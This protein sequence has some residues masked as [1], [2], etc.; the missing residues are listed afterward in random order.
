MHLKQV[1]EG[2]ELFFAK[3]ALRDVKVHLI[4]KSAA[5]ISDQSKAFFE[6]LAFNNLVSVCSQSGYPNATITPRQANLPIS[7]IV[8]GPASTE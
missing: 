6:N 2:G 4:L 7:P 1:D 8:H 5:P 3:E